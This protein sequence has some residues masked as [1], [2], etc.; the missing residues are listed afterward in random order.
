MSTVVTSVPPK[1]IYSSR[2]DDPELR[3]PIN[4]FVISLAERVDRLQDAEVTGNLAE[5]SRLS[6]ELCKVA[7][8]L[9][10]GPLVDVA[11]EVG[12]AAKDEKP[13]AALDAL[14]KLTDVSQRIRLGHRG[15]A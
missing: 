10:Y 4:E 7:E 9:G 5:L 11:R 15:S 3:E 13:D 12:G 6:D 2:E 8:R 1:P 14:E